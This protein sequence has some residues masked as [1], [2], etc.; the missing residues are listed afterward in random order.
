MEEK[1][2]FEFVRGALDFKIGLLSYLETQ[3]L[4]NEYLNSKM[5]SVKL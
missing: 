2:L 1:L 3:I 5:L 4:A